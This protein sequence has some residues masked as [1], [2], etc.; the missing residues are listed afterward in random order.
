MRG[1]SLFKANNDRIENRSHYGL[2]ITYE[3]FRKAELYRVIVPESLDLTEVKL[4]S[5]LNMD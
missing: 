4:T 5:I 1:K 2:K 3:T